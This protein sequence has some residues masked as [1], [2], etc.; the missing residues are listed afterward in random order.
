MSEQITLTLP[1]GV[2]RRVEAFAK[3]SG[4]PMGELLAETI[5]LTFTPLGERSDDE[6][7]ADSE[8]AMADADNRRLSE[9]LG[10]QSEGQLSQSD[11]EELAGLMGLYERLLLRKAQAL[12]EA[13]RRGLR[14]PVAP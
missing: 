13:V 14:G 1:L 8:I 12:E 7:I 3:R 4:R 5:E 2:Y 9:L 10:L 6:V 11:R